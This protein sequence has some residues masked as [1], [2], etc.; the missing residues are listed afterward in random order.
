ME[1]SESIVSRLEAKLFLHDCTEF[2]QNTDTVTEQLK[3]QQKYCER[4][5][6]LTIGQVTQIL[7]PNIRNIISTYPQIREL[8]SP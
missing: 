5:V 3:T 1:E 2:L 6:L 4:W 7:Q 8:S